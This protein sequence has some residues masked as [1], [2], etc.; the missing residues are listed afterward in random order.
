MSQEEE[1]KKEG[2]EKQ[3]TLGEPR[4][5]ECV[6]LYKSLGYEVRLEPIDLSKLS[7]ECK[8]CLVCDLTTIRT[9]YIRKKKR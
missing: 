7:E 4:L 9:I 3:A 2:W 8:R 6:Q 5:S 1:L